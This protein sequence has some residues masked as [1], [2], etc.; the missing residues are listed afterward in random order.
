[1]HP[2][3]S[4]QK[5]KRKKKKENLLYKGFFHPNGPQCENKRKRK[6]RQVLRPCLRNEKGEEYEGYSDTNCSW[7]AWNGS[8]RL[9]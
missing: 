6:G 9:G 3:P 1:M 8:Q 5:K 2:W 7:H 4:R